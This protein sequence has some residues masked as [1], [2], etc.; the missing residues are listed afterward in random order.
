IFENEKEESEEFTEFID[1]I[2]NKTEVT[3]I[4][5]NSYPFNDGDGYIWNSSNK[6]EWQEF[7]ESISPSSDLKR[8]LINKSNSALLIFKFKNKE[9]NPYTF[10]MC[11]GKA[12]LYIPKGLINTQFGLKVVL[13]SSNDNQFFSLDTISLF[14]SKLVSKKHSLTPQNINNLF[15][16]FSDEFVKKIGSKCKL[17]SIPKESI[18]LEGAS[19]ISLPLLTNLNDIPSILNEVLEKYNTRDLEDKFPFFGRFK[20]IINQLEE[21]RLFSELIKLYLEN[22]ESIK[23]E[24]LPHNVEEDND[25]CIQYKK[26]SKQDIPENENTNLMYPLQLIQ[27][28]YKDNMEANKCIEKLNEFEIQIKFAED[29]KENTKISFKECLIVDWKFD[30]E[31]YFLCENNIYSISEKFHE[32]VENKYAKISQNNNSSS[33]DNS[34]NNIKFYECESEYNAELAIKSKGALLDQRLISGIEVC[35]VLTDK[36]E[37]IHCKI[38]KSSQSLSHLFAQSIVSCTNLMLDKKFMQE[39]KSELTNPSNFSPS[40]NCKSY[41]RQYLDIGRHNIINF[42]ITNFKVIFLIIKD[43]N[44]EINSLPY[45]SKLMLITTVS[46]LERMGI[47]SSLIIKKIQKILPSK[48]F[49]KTS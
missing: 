31:Y 35:D 38:F 7:I 1:K 24:I 12:S 23:F 5:L 42:P 30:N 13:A 9:N 11:F 37:F 41:R 44:G 34:I 25:I 16:F 17:D 36:Y 32:L 20:K 21:R 46:Q 49:L 47:E 28:L 15:D 2:S 48:A 40:E 10:L 8:E 4:R 39:L 6:C 18:R 19:G 29:D 27:K 43:G 33:I 22:P 3:K 26:K 45:F 14:Y